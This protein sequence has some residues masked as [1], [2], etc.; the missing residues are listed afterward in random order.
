MTR[1]RIVLLITC[2][3]LAA[4]RAAAE[5]LYA[6][7]GAYRPEMEALHEALEVDAAHGWTVTEIKGIEF[8]RGTVGGKDVVV[9]STGVSTVNAAYRLQLALERFPI[10]HVLFGGVAGGTDPSLDVGDI[11]IPAQWAY[12]DEA[13]YLNE[14][15]DNPGEYLVPDYLR[16]KIENYGMIFPDSVHATRGDGQGG[17]EMPFF[18]ADPELLD[19]ARRVLPTLP[20]MEK[21]GRIVSLSVGGNGVAGTVF[22]DNAKYR[23]WIFRIWQARCLDMESTALAHVTW[24]NQTP[25]LVVRGLSD[26]AGGQHGKNPIDDNELGVSQIAA[27][28]V[29]AIIEAH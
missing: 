2:T 25:I 3:L 7:L 15:P 28:V 24:S 13:A 5:N 10:T 1:L 19:V 27:R 26:L 9:F 6:V 29:R 20:P 11:V 4:T 17:R 18:P 23:E 12:H 22:L 21:N 16:P 14:D 8:W